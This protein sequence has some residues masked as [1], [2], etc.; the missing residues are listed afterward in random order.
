MKK[1]TVIF[2]DIDG[3]LNGRNTKDRIGKVKGV[4]DDKM[5]LLK[6]IAEILDADLILSS[7]WRDFW[8]ED[9]A[10]DGVTSWKGNS[11]KRF[12]RYLNLRLADHGLS[13]AGKTGFIRSKKRGEEI[14]QWLDLHPEVNRFVILDD[15]DFRWKENG[16]ARNWV[17]TMPEGDTT[18]RI[19]DGLKREHVEYIRKN[20]VQFDR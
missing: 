16:L 17:C 10:T 9:L 1:S 2:L 7:T 19:G 5:M 4:E 13:I 11:L 8:T 15:E 12:G 18:S 14:L 20:A 3:V 6:E